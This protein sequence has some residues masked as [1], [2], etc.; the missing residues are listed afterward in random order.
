MSHGNMYQKDLKCSTCKAFRSP[1]NSA[2]LSSQP[3]KK[4]RLS[5][6]CPLS[7]F[8]QICSFSLLCLPGHP[9]LWIT[10]F[11]GGKGYINISPSEYLYISVMSCLSN[12][13]TALVLIFLPTLS[14]STVITVGG[15]KTIKMVT[16]YKCWN[17]INTTNF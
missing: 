10:A 4:Q 16:S 7:R 14:E 1:D 8:F 9:V 17:L 15:Y 12:L 11:K 3:P 5:I 2:I 13:P 6:S